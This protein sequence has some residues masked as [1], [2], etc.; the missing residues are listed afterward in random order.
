MS[1]IGGIVGLRNGGGSSVGGLVAW[2][3]VLNLNMGKVLRIVRVSDRW[4]L[5]VLVLVLVLVLRRRGWLILMTIASQ[6]RGL[7]AGSVDGQL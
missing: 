2:L 7:G 4:M 1:V 5:L 6:G 3:M